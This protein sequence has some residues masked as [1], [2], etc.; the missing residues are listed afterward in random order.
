M[1][2]S[3]LL[4]ILGFVMF[5]ISFL[6]LEISDNL[7]LFFIVL[8]TSISCLVA[9]FYIDYKADTKITE[10]DVYSVETYTSDTNNSKIYKF[11]IRREDNS[12][13]QILLTED[14]AKLY[15]RDNKFFIS[16]TELKDKS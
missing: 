9:G 14:E 13:V 4:M 10:Y 15:Y 5:I 8:F 11:L 2:I 6:I 1:F 3:A 12:Y 16:E 7:L